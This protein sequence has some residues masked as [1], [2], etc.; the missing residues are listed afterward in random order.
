VRT[1]KVP[2]HPPK[3]FELDR[4]K[5]FAGAGGG[6]FGI[7]SALPRFYI[8]N[9]MG[10]RKSPIRTVFRWDFGSTQPLVSTR[11]SCTC[12]R[13]VSIAANLIFP[14]SLADLELEMSSRGRNLA[15]IRTKLNIRFAT[16]TFLSSF[17]PFALLLT[18]SFWAIR[19]SVIATVR[20]D[21][22]AS[23]RDNQVALAH[24][25]ARDQLRDR[26]WLQGVAENPTLTKGLQLLYTERPGT[27]RDQ[28]HRSAEEQARNAVLDLTYSTKKD[29][30]RNTI[31]NQL[32]EICDSL[33]FDF[34][35]VSGV[36]G[37][38]LAAVLRNGG[39]FAPISLLDQHP[40]EEGFFSADDRVYEVTSVMI[41][42]ADAQVATLTVGGAF[43][44]SRF[45]VPAVLVHKGL[46]VAAQTRDLTPAQ[47]EKALAGCGAGRECEPQIGNQSYL[48]LPLGVAGASGNDS[49]ILRS[50]QNVDA[51][52]APLQAVLRKLFLVAGLAALAAMLGITIFSSRSIARPLADVAAHLRRSAV[53]GDLPEF[54]ESQSGVYEIRDLTQGFNAASKAVR[55]AREQLTLAYVQFV[56]SL[57]HALDARDAYTAGH[58][59]RV[60]EYSCAIA[61]V[62]TVPEQDLETIRVGALLHDLGKIGIP[63]LVL[64]KP[65]RLTPE[66]NELIQQ[67]PVIG[68]RILE[69]VHGMEAYLDIVELHHE[70]LDGSGYPH[71]LK[72]EETP[73]DARIVKVADAYD[74]I[75]SDR[76]YRRGKSHADAIA[77]LRKACGSEVDPAVVEAF[78]GLGDQLKQQMALEGDQSLHSLSRMVENDARKALPAAPP[79]PGPTPPEA[80]DLRGVRE[81]N[82]R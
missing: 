66:E 79:P 78:A 82:I 14:E 31:E 41:H 50:L 54:P 38:P 72:G 67:H 70:N 61:R 73:L 16:R 5:V 21:L 18:V 48:S 23:V 24:E 15:P 45:G 20:N 56:G 39:G 81:S 55:E 47:I 22:R 29:E 42:E 46:V 34:I 58:S 51:A 32:S 6:L 40:P 62:M 74:A 44:I 33:G 28:S 53:T 75:T 4:D 35:M 76:P 59:R 12:L 77:I 71:G 11:T 25:Q 30:A 57:A 7:C 3:K 26:K 17:V 13:S 52:S 10:S 63:D 43:D 1:L 60:S 36:N 80:N 19:S 49:Y 2:A 37:E 65:G 8:D 64:Q 68:K 9:L 69:N 27:V